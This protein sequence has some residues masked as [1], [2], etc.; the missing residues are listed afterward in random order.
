MYGE[1]LNNV[2][3][4]MALTPNSNLASFVIPIKIDKTSSIPGIFDNGGKE[5]FILEIMEHTKTSHISLA[6]TNVKLK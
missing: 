3:M 1:F 6:K 2:T 5:N 4:S